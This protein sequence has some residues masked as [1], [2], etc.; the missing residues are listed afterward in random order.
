[1]D[2]GLRRLLVLGKQSTICYTASAA[3]RAR[4]GAAV[5]DRRAAHGLCHRRCRAGIVPRSCPGFP[6]QCRTP[7]PCRCRNHAR[8]HR[9]IRDAIPL[10]SADNELALSDSDFG[11]SASAAAA[12]V[13]SAVSVEP[14]QIGCACGGPPPNPRDFTQPPV[15]NLR[16][17][18]KGWILY[19]ILHFVCPT[20]SYGHPAERPIPCTDSIQS[21]SAGALSLNR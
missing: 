8:P 11:A 6:A 16:Q 20:A 19:T 4:A 15:W 12:L 10:P 14:R 3:N 9:A 13:F 2:G 21:L 7:Y 18:L 17:P 5:A 1:V